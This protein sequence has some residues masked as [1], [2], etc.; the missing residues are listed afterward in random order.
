[1][2]DFLDAILDIGEIYARYGVKGCL[3]A[4]LALVVVIA[5]VIGLAMVLG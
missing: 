2:G 5:A 1:M 3:F 4:I